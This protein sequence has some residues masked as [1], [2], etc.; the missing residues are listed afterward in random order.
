VDIIRCSYGCDESVDR[1]LHAVVMEEQTPE[2]LT[3]PVANP[4][5]TRL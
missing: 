4:R 1:L 5:R 2:I 3:T